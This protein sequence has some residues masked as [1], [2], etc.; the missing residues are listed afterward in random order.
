MQK[1]Q[2]KTQLFNTTLDLLVEETNQTEAILQTILSV[3][4]QLQSS[5]N[6]YDPN[7]EISKL[8]TDKQ[9]LASP[10]LVE[11]LDIAKKYEVKTD[12]Y[13]NTNQQF[14]E[15]NNIELHNNLVRINYPVDLGGLAKGY[16][17]ALVQSLLL[18][19]DLSFEM[20]F[21]GSLLLSS[22]KLIT[23]RSMTNPLENCIQFELPKLTSIHTSSYYFQIDGDQSHIHSKTDNYHILNKSVSVISANPILADVFS[24]ALYCMPIDTALTYISKYNLNVIY[25][26]NSDIYASRELVENPNFQLLNNDMNLYTI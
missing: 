13:F 26:Y 25:C 7:S 2:L 23:I 6:I 8:N 16:F 11:I 14:I 3:A 17:M 19:K 12:Y 18:K 22:N 24:T 9:L 1:L 15:E 5:F 21:G 20:N 10:Y 4:S